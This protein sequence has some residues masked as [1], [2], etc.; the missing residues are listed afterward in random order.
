M[1]AVAEEEEEEEVE[2]RRHEEPSLPSSQL[3]DGNR[4]CV[5]LFAHHHTTPF[6]SLG[7]DGAQCFICPIRLSFSAS[8]AL[9]SA[10]ASRCLT[11]LAE[12]FL[13]N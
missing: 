4:S 12:P 1:R 13:Y 11:H 8:P 6:P 5:S 7:A 10:L 2:S 3:M 9:R